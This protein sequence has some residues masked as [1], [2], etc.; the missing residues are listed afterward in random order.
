MV[1]HRLQAE[2]E[3]LYATPLPYDVYDFL[4]T[5]RALA[6][7]LT[8]PGAS[9]SNQERLLVANE[10]D[11]ASVSLYL[12][13]NL[14]AAL[15]RD[16]PTDCLH[17]KNLP[18]FLLALEGVSH[19]NYVM[20]NAERNTAVSLLE[21]ELQSEVDKYVTCAKLLAQQGAGNVPA[22]LHRRLFDEVSF[23]ESLGA[24]ARSRYVEANHFAARY[25]HSLRQRYPQHHYQPGFLRELRGFYRLP[26]MQKIGHIRAQ[27]H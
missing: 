18:A 10:E 21:V 5:D 17:A 1:L 7:A 8:P 12:D 6:D 4:I 13:A 11:G 24:Q 3:A 9:T 15:E 27:A 14:L 19:L 22:A 26:Q 23:D 20:W 2:L 25:C 16:D